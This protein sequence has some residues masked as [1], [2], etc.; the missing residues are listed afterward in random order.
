[1]PV[2]PYV[3][4][5]ADEGRRFHTLD[6]T[7]LLQGCWPVARELLH[8]LAGDARHLLVVDARWDLLP[9]VASDPLQLHLYLTQVPR[10]AQLRLDEGMHGTWYVSIQRVTEPLG[11]CHPEGLGGRVRG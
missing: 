1:M 5:Q 3:R 11:R 10:V 7:R 4:V 6:R 2:L 8:L 9:P